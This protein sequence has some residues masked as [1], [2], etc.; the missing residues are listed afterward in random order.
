MAHASA[1]SFFFSLSSLNILCEL[2]RYMHISSL[3]YFVRVPGDPRARA[4]VLS[5]PMHISRHATLGAA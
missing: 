2:V 5:A 3:V 4:S 1:G